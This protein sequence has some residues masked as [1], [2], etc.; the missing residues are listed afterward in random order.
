MM[1]DF[2]FENDTQRKGNILK[3]YNYGILGYH[4][5]YLYFIYLS[6][7]CSSFVTVSI[8]YRKII[9]YR[10]IDCKCS[11]NKCQYQT[12]I[13][14]ADAPCVEEFELEAPAVEEML[15]RVVC[16]REQFSF[17]MCLEGG[18][19]SGTIHSW[20]QSSRQLVP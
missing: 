13:G 19:G 15:D 2:A 12:F 5:N 4:N 9:Q 14:V 11:K 10:Y 7:S 16:S 17:Q 18:D 6:S 3:K 1:I 8:S 20:R